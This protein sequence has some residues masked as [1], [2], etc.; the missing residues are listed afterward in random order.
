MQSMPSGTM[1]A[2]KTSLAELEKIKANQFEIAAENAPESC[3]ISFDTQNTQQVEELLDKNDIMYLQ[4]NTWH[5]FHSKTFDPILKE[6]ESFVNDCKASPPQIPFISCLTGDFIS[7]E[8]AVSGAYWAKQLRNTVFFQ[9]GISSVE[10]L[11]NTM[12][13]EVGPNSHLRSNLTAAYEENA[14]SKICILTLGKPLKNNQNILQKIKGNIWCYTSKEFSDFKVNS[15]TTNKIPLPTYPFEKKRYWVEHK[16]EN[17][18]ST[19]TRQIPE[20]PKIIQDTGDLNNVLLSIWKTHFGRDDISLTDNFTDLGGESML[21]FSI[22][23]DIERQLQVKISFRDFMAEFNTIEKVMNFANKKIEEKSKAKI[24]DGSFKYIYNINP[25]S[26]ENVPVFG[27]YCDKIFLIKDA[28]KDRPIYDFAWPG[29][30]G[31][32][33]TMHTV[34]EIADT[35]LNEILQVYS[36]KTFYL[37][38]FSFGGQIAYD[39]AVK[40]RKL[41]YSVPI[42]GIIDSHYP[43]LKIDNNPIQTL[44]DKIREHGYFNLF[45]TRLLNAIKHQLKERFSEAK[46]FIYF[47]LNKKLPLKLAHTMIYNESV[48]ILKK[49][50]PQN[51]DGRIHLFRSLDNFIEDDFLGW[52]PYVKDVIKYDLIGSHMDTVQHEQNKRTINKELKMIIEEEESTKTK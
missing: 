41:G 3:T 32:P 7:N 31:R 10:S 2:V 39:I 43:Q 21:A 35:Y 37:I 34:E 12:Y 36:G 42:L 11:K 6:F 1:F 25:G 4:L 17:N 23:A 20:E 29:S 15:T 40:L 8:D 13:I 30:D 44:R 16:Y 18:I 49:Y 22:I 52:S 24:L 50:N 46:I 28:I 45:T 38:G 51:F 33:F 5:A 14:I 19:T 27:I 47:K 9:K 48:K 26:S